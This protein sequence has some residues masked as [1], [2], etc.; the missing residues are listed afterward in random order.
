MRGS[1]INSPTASTG[2]ARVAVT[3]QM[4]LFVTSF[5]PKKELNLPEESLE[6]W[7]NGNGGARYNFQ[8]C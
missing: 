5:Y 6:A 3:Y 8:L 2:V 7:A 1:P 4:E